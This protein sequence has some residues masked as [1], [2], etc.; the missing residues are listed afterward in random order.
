MQNRPDLDPSL[1]RYTIRYLD[2]EKGWLLS[3]W[4]MTIL[5][6]IKQYA[7]LEWEPLMETEEYV[8]PEDIPG[9]GW[10][11]RMSTSAFRKTEG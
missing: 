5:Y 11:G 7:G 9:W 2:G 6:A 8:R 4:K 10:D 3:P 1:P